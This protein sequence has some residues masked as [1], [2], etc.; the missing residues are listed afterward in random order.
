MEEEKQL[1]AKKVRKNVYWAKLEKYLTEYKNILIITVDFVGSK[2][3]QQVRAAIRGKG[4]V[5]MGKNTIMRKVIRENM[6]KHPKLASLLPMIKGNMGFIFTKGDLNEIRKT[7]T[8]FKMPAA[9][10]AGVIAPVDVTIPPGPTS[11]DPGQTSFFQTLNVATRISKGC[12]EITGEVRL[13]FKGEKVSASAVALLA[14]LGIKPFEFGIEVP[15]VYEDGSVYDASVLDLEQSDLIAK[16]GSAVA[17]VS[18]IS[19]EINEINATTIPH[20]FG[21]AFNTLIAIALGTEYEFEEL[22]KVKEQMASGGG[23]GGGAAAGGE[24]AAAPV[25]EEEE[26]EEEAAPVDMFGDGGDEEDY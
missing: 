11:L 10:K 21:K 18:A 2:Q 15:T 9:A 17:M 16:F 14:K 25:E 12:I 24:A 26:E 23:S 22:T 8:S 1:S 4:E 5:L 7:V 20:S 6:E 19:Y 3:M 13:C